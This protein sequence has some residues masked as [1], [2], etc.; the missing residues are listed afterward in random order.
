MGS[1]PGRLGREKIFSRPGRV[2]SARRRCSDNYNRN[3]IGI[4]AYPLYDEGIGRATRSNQTG[5]SDGT[6]V[7]GGCLVAALAAAAPATADEAPK[8]GGILTYVIP[9][10]SPPSF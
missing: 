3:L 10:D 2:S 6:K 7:L 5:G 1:E 8:Y 4:F 9:A